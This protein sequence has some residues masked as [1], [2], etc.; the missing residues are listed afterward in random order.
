MQARR[1]RALS[2]SVSL[3]FALLLT[4]TATV[5]AKE[6][7]DAAVVRDGSTQERAIINGQSVAT[8]EQ[9]EYRY[10]DKHFPGR[11][12]LDHRIAADAATQRVWSVFTFMW[13]GGKTTFWFDVTQ[14]FN[15]F[16]RT[17]PQ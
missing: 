2:I 3:L 12:P 11:K 7:K 13:H 4:S 1:M 17:H 15:E 6:P 16:R 5:R 9:W 14:P 8:H 10:L